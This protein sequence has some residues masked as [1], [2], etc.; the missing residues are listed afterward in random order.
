MVDKLAGQGL[1]DDELVE[2]AV[3]GDG[4]A[5]D[6]L[7]NKYKPLV[8]LR[9]HEYFIAGA[10]REDIIQEG[11]IGLYKAIRD[12]DPGRRVPFYYFAQ[13]CITRQIISAIKAAARHK[14]A[15]LNTYVSLN[16]SAFDSREKSMLETIPAA[17]GSDPEELVIGREGKEYLETH[18]GEILSEMEC[19]V[20]ALHLQGHSYAQ[21][22]G[23]IGKDE[24]SVDNAV[25]RVRRKIEKFLLSSRKPVARSQKPAV[26]S[27]KN[28][29]R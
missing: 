28:T 7:F 23:A 17:R 11:M 24:K 5:Q 18:V 3:R 1:T 27:R 29:R 21:I 2:G 16:K 19:R 14:H 10:D 15:P 12:Y 20:L 25:Q 4:D 8:K 13:L 26:S 9:A 6:M 22:A